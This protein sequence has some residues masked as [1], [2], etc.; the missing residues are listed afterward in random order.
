MIGSGD[1]LAIEDLS[2]RLGERTVLANLSCLLPPGCFVAVV[3]PN[4]AGKTSLLRALCG[5]VPANGTVR[6]QTDDLM[7]LAAPARA[8]R[9]AYLPQGH[10]VH[11]PMPARDV[12][13]LGRFPH[14]ATDPSRLRRADSEAVE[15]AMIRTGC[16]DLAGRDVRLLSGGERARVMLARVLAVEAPILLV[17]EPTA[18]LDPRQQ[19]AI[20]GTLRA[21]ARRGAL[22]IAVTH[23]LTLAARMADRVLLLH[24]GRLVAQGNPAST[25]SDANLAATYGVSVLRFDHAGETVLVP[26]QMTGDG[27]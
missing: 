10:V 26:W 1:G 20:M 14:G 5:L 25:L 9:I 21:E 19:L 27:T 12:V 3:G 15:A 2:I 8:R 18:A 4:G 6:W 13:A 22:V 11:W 23:D 17:D 7:R 24:E 16:L